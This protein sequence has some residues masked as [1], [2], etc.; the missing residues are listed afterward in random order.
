MV[1]VETA[2]KGESFDKLVEFSERPHIF[3]ETKEN[4]YRTKVCIFNEIMILGFC[5]N[6][7]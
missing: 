2:V 5:K 7:D 6:L 1:K 4:Q 3:V